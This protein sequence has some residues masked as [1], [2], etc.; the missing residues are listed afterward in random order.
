MAFNNGNIRCD[1]VLLGTA[2]LAPCPTANT[3]LAIARAIR[4][5]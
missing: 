4:M 1:T 3:L 2:N 5:K